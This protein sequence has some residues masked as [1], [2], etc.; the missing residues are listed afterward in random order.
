MARQNETPLLFPYEP[1]EFWNEIRKIFKEELKVAG[2]HQQPSKFNLQTP[3]LVE[4]PLYRIAEI[5]MLFDV[6]RT[7]VH[8]W[9]KSGQLRKIKVRSR[10]YFLQAD[11]KRLFGNGQPTT[12]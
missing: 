11:V 12:V 8:E 3:G 5:C 1:E 7:T 4:K 2:I 9:V 6:S 10:V